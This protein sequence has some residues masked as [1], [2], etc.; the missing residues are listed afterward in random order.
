MTLN[1]TELDLRAVSL[2]LAGLLAK[3]S[4][5]PDLLR[6]LLAAHEIA[7]AAIKRTTPCIDAIAQEFLRIQGERQATTPAAPTE[8]ASTQEERKTVH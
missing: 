5:Q 2:V 6:D 1:S 4:G 7:H 8:S 3:Y